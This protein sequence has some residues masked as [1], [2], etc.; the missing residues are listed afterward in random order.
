VLPKCTYQALDMQWA[1]I[2]T[3]N[4][5]FVP[6]LNDRLVATCTD[7]TRVAPDEK[8][9]DIVAVCETHVTEHA[10]R[11]SDEDRRFF[12]AAH[13]RLKPN[14]FLVWGNAIPDST[15]DPCFEYLE[16]IGMKRVDV[17]DVTDH[18]VRARDEDEARMEAYVAQMLERFHW[19]FRIP[20]VGA[21]RR[22]EAEV[23]L[24]NFARHPG[25]NL[26]QNMVTRTDTYRV[27]LFQKT[28]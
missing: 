24:K 2:Q 3:C 28:A 16:S 4:R 5:K 7:A 23:A 17:H 9:A 1:A 8:P 6:N 21:K 18:A 25:T 10:G 15:W 26:Y 22:V 12:R 19:G 13:R 20:V 27:G 11:C 14:G